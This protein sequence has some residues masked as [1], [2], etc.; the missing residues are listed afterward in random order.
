MMMMKPWKFLFSVICRWKRLVQH[1]P[2]PIIGFWRLR[3]AVEQEFVHKLE[4]HQPKGT[5]RRE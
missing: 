5:Q 4:T 3:P 1:L 2:L